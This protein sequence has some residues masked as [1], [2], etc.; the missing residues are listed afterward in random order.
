MK[1]AAPQMIKTVLAI[2]LYSSENRF[3]FFLRKARR[4]LPSEQQRG[5]A[6]KPWK[7]IEV[8]PKVWGIVHIGKQVKELKKEKTDKDETPPATVEAIVIDDD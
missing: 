8:N 6:R 5:I 4:T 7:E 1:T 3:F 2:S